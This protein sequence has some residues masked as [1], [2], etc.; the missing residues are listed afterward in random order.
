MLRLTEFLLHGHKCDAL[1]SAAVSLTATSPMIHHLITEAL[2]EAL[3]FGHTSL[4]AEEGACVGRRQ[5]DVWR[6]GIGSAT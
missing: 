4:I 3:G 1:K 2:V 5:E 6:G